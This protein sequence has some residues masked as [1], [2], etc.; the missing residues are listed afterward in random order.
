MRDTV[1]VGIYGTGN[2]ANKQH[3]PNLLRI[4]EA[5]I[6][7]LCDI[8][9][10][11]LSATAEMVPGARTYTDAHQMLERETLDALYSCVPAF[12]R[13]DVEA[14]AAARGIHLFSEKPQALDFSIA[15]TIDEAIQKSG[16]I[17][18][19]GFR[20]RYRPFFDEARR[21]LSD[22]LLT[23]VQFVQYRHLPRF[24]DGR[25]AW[26]DDVEKSGGSALDWGVHAV[27]ITRFLTNL[28]LTKA[29]A[30][31]LQREGYALPLT[32][33]LHFQ[34][35]NEATMTLTIISSLSPDTPR[36]PTR[37]AFF[38][39]GGMLELFMYERI[40]VDGQVVFTA[41]PFDPWFEH[42]QRFV[43]AVATD[44]S[45]LLRNDYHDGLYTLAPLLAGWES[46]RRGGETL[47][48]AG[49]MGSSDGAL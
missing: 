1:R 26:Y 33:S 27:D 9:P 30:F 41:E 17:S 24:R 22:R 44:D 36:V 11:N 45:S 8:D 6:V 7:A 39:E 43:R 48:V 32:S 18:T 20:E 15:R 23:H 2:F 38:Y 10:D 14:T 16:V 28:D 13:T 34:L 21:L 47:D 3:I 46:A 35:S 4:P 29:Q 5:Q 19:V 40:E 37:F 42:D 25:R 12:A 31:Y 49:F